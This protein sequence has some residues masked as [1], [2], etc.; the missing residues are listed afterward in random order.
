MIKLLGILALIGLFLSDPVINAL[1]TRPTL[2]GAVVL[3]GFGLTI[4]YRVYAVVSQAK[5]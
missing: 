1:R 2:F 3:I 4:M 5:S